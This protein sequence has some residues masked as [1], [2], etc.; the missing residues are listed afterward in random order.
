M[1]PLDRATTI[2]IMTSTTT[3]VKIPTPIPVLKMPPITLHELRVTD[4]KMAR[5]HE[6]LEKVFMCRVF[7]GFLLIT[8]QKSFQSMKSEFSAN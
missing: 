8:C 4:R 2:P 1:P 3:T 7:K 6:A 5:K